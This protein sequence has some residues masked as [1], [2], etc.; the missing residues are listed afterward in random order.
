MTLNKYHGLTM[1]R[2]CKILRELAG[3]SLTAG[4]LSQ[5]IDRVADRVVGDCEGLVNQ[6]RGSPAV[7]ADETSWWVGG[8]GWWLWTFT[9]PEITVYRVDESRGAK[10]VEDVLGE[11]FAGVL[12]SDCLSSYDPP[13]YRKHKCIAHHLR[14][15]RS[16]TTS[17]I[18]TS[19]LRNPGDITSFLS[20]GE[21]SGR[22]PAATTPTAARAVA[23]EGLR[24][25]GSRRKPYGVP[26]IRRGGMRGTIAELKTLPAK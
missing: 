1:R 26:G 5:M 4:G 13:T 22:S 16:T 2:T 9:C 10:V 18:T 17:T 11:D 25:R 14:A 8:P 19:K 24:G 6:I 15:I 7:N 23:P 12:V 20:W 21:V 3:L